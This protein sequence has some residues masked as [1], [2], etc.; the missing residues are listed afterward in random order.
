MDLRAERRLSDRLITETPQEHE[1][2]PVTATIFMTPTRVPEGSSLALGASRFGGEPDLP[3]GTAWPTREGVPMQFVAQIRLADLA[4]YDIDQVLPTSGSLLFFHNEQCESSEMAGEIE[5]ARSAWKI[6]ADPRFA[7]FVFS[8]GRVLF[9]PG[10]DAALI[11]TPA[12]RVDYEDDYGR[13]VAPELYPL[14]ALTFANTLE[15]PERKPD[16]KGPIRY[17][18]HQLLGDIMAEDNI[19]TMTDGDILLCQI[20]SDFV[21]GF[22]WGELALLYFVATRADIAARDFSRIRLHRELS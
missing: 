20:D 19:E 22:N 11:R 8:C 7:D 15:I 1:R 3:P 17:R 21:A 4:A 6:A 9:W 12:P 18:H 10:D 2:L 5:P 16:D 14:C 13:R